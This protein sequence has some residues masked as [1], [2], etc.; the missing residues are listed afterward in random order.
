MSGN[1]IKDAF[2]EN[3]GDNTWDTIRIALDENLSEECIEALSRTMHSAL[4]K[5]GLDADIRFAE[6]SRAYEGINILEID[7]NTLKIHSPSRTEESTERNY[8]S[9]I[10]VQEIKEH[11]GDQSC[12]Y[13]KVVES[14]NEV[15]NELQGFVTFEVGPHREI[16]FQKKSDYR[17][18]DAKPESHY[19]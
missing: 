2:D 19:D 13:N 10:T 4:I 16:L 6:S 14:C 12:F 11:S 15:K 9:P 3:R 5:R 17:F 1:E 7:I 8:V 18:E